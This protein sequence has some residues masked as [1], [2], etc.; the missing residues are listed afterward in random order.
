MKGLLA[1]E[2]G[3]AMISEATVIMKWSSRG[4]PQTLPPMRRRVSQGPVV[5]VHD[6]LPDDAAHVDAKGVALMDVVVDGRC[7]GLLAAVM[8]CIIT[9]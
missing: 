3:P 4:K 9:N 7:P 6:P 2:L 5:H 8:A 1:A